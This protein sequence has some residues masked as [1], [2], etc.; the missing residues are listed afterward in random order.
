MADS[1]R[2][3][4]LHPSRHESTPAHQNGLALSD[5]KHHLQKSAVKLVGY[6][7]AAYL[8]LKLVP[9]L[10]E[11]LRSLEHVAWEWVVGAIAIEVLSETGFVISWRGSLTRSARR[12]FT[13]RVRYRRARCRRGK[14]S[15]TGV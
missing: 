10:E 13:R 6:L 4:V 15:S 7:V 1:V 5:A 2:S 11:A 9:T 14:C 8:V 12:E 3:P